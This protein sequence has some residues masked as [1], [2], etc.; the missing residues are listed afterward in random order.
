MQWIHVWILILR[1]LPTPNLSEVG[2][3]IAY[4]YFTFMF[5]QVQFIW[6]MTSFE[7]WNWSANIQMAAGAAALAQ[8]PNETLFAC[9]TYCSSNCCSHVVAQIMP[10][11]MK[12]QNNDP[13]LPDPPAPVGKSMSVGLKFDKRVGKTFTR[14]G[15]TLHPWVK[16]LNFTRAWV[17]L[18]HARVKFYTRG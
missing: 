6:S 3:D 7:G 18:L 15:K 12:C 1:G 5:A 14:V 17:K 9:R 10:W 13:T 2:N 16:P 11:G 8:W 4:L